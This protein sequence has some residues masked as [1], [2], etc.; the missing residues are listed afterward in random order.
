MEEIQLDEGSDG[1]MIYRTRSLSIQG[2]Y[3]DAGNSV[4]HGILEQSQS[5]AHIAGGKD[6]SRP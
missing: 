2:I 3:L 6:V 1:R 5:S 4:V